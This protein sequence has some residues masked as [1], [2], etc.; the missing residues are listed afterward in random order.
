MA[1]AALER[2]DTAKAELYARELLALAEDYRTD[3]TY[4]NAVH[5]G[6]VVLGLAALV[7]GDRNLAASE[8]LAAGRTPGSPQ[9]RS[10]GPNMQLAAALLDLGIREPVLEYLE[11]CRSFWELGHARLDQWTEE[12]RDGRVVQFG[13]NL[14]Y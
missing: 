1:L 5:H 2:S 11:L 3:W 14:I 6:H 4:G 8:L 13:A 9:L 12:I 7:R 10:F